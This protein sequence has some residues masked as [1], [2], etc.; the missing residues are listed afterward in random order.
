MVDPYF[1]HPNKSDILI[2]KSLSAD[3][4]LSPQADGRFY[5]IIRYS[6]DPTN[7]ALL[8]L[9]NLANRIYQSLNDDW[10]MWLLLFEAYIRSKGKRFEKGQFIDI[11]V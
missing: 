11:H 1:E 10:L 3:F 4:Y 6:D 5:G 7:T 2:G 9:D 8:S